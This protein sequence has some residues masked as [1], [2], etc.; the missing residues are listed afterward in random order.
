M[1]DFLENA[2]RIAPVVVYDLVAR[3]SPGAVFLYFAGL[4]GRD[5]SAS[6]NT[7]QDLGILS[8]IFGGYIVG[9]LL[10]VISSIIFDGPLQLLSRWSR[11]YAH[12]S[13]NAI[14]NQID[15]LDFRSEKHGIL[16]VKIE[17]EMTLCQNLFVAFWGLV[18]LQYGGYLAGTN[19]LLDLGRP[20]AWFICIT[21]LA[22][23][24][25]RTG[26]VVQRVKVIENL[27]S[28]KNSGKA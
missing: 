13:P 21:L 17:A 10:T 22:A 8:L 3:I 11:R 26:I 23:V 9:I 2:S 28:S 6:G 20:L 15:S 12:L 18:A 7:A 19:P 16:L 4:S 25:H 14:W 27:L 24:I 1:A 5:F